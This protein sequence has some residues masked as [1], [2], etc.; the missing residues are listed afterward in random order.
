MEKTITLE[1][2]VESLKK[3]SWRINLGMG[4]KVVYPDEITL[5][6]FGKEAMEENFIECPK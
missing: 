6:L 5:D 3:N 4:P 2:L 1:Q